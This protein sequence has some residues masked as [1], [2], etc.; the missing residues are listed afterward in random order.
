MRILYVITQ[1]ELGGAQIYVETLAKAARK[2]SD[3]VIV[4]TNKNNDKHLRSTLEPSGVKIWPLGHLVQPISPWS[5]CMAVFELAKLYQNTKPDIIHLNSSKAGVVGSFAAIWTQ[6]FHKTGF[7]LI[8]TAHGWVFNEPMLLLKKW[9]YIFLEKITAPIKDKIICVSEFDRQIGVKSRIAPAAK[10]IAILN[11]IDPNDINLLPRTESQI[12]LGLSEF[13]NE[14]ILCAISNFYPAKGLNYLL[15]AVKILK[16]Q[17]VACRLAII[18]E[19]ALR[20]QLE[21]QIKELHLEHYVIIAGRLN[22]ASR[23]LSAGDIAVMSSV[24][25]GLPYFP[26]EAMAA[27]LPVVATN[28]GGLP[29]II[30]DGITGFIVPAQNPI[31]LA[32]KISLLASNPQLRQQMG[33]AGYNRVKENFSEDDM[34]NKT[35]ATYQ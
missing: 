22:Q 19:G 16:E 34:I 6:L 28:A 13:N 2:R 32:K 31:A 35:F 26:L 5:D 18:G 25:E 10:L 1:G 7:R 9:L 3:E 12:A 33:E 20:P 8:Y 23:Y 29:E 15:E 21:Q 14:L 11:G 30:D 17:G 24:K 4:A 27:Q